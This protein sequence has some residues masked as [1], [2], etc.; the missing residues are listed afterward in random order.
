[1]LSHCVT[2]GLQNEGRPALACPFS[3]SSTVHC[4]CLKG[5]LKVEA[6]EMLHTSDELKRLSWAAAGVKRQKQPAE[7]R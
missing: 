4:G 1:V 7:L 6:A 5:Y 2:G 3:C